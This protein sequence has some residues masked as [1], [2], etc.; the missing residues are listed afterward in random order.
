MYMNN[1]K[2]EF[3]ILIMNCEFKIREMAAPVS[4]HVHLVATSEDDEANLLWVSDDG[5][6]HQ[7]QAVQVG[8]A[9]EQ[10]TFPGHKWVLRGTQSG[11]NLL[12]IVAEQGPRMQRHVVDERIE[13]PQYRDENVGQT[14]AATGRTAQDAAGSADVLDTDEAEEEAGGMWESSEGSRFQRVR[15]MA[16]GSRSIVWN[17]VSVD[18]NTIATHEQVEIA[19]PTQWFWW[20][21]DLFSKIRNMNGER[22][23]MMFYGMSIAG[24]YQL[25]AAE[26]W[27]PW[28]RVATYRLG[29]G[30]HPLV[31]LL[32]MIFLAGACVAAATPITDVSLVLMRKDTGVH[33]KLTTRSGYM[34]NAP[35]RGQEAPVWREVAQGK[36]ARLPR[37]LQVLRGQRSHHAVFLSLVALWVSVRVKSAFFD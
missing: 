18:G 37:D 26:M 23:Q 32:F 36:F 4:L 16:G 25:D 27:P 29:L 8:R 17:E 13:P 20:S 6:E 34:R 7:Y 12:I 28:L 15:R 9:V 35:R 31:A 10:E 2:K 3:K 19:C 1:V 5:V 33:T 21:T 22:E 11:R 30:T 24:A 14:V